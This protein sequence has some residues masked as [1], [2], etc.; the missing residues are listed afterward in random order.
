[1]DQNNRIAVILNNDITT[2]TVTIPAYQ[3]SM[4][5]G[6]TVTDK[7]TGK[8]YPVQNGQVTVTLQGHYGAILVQ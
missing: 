6:S 8:S 3:L 2:H 5:D 1:M 4:T 7:I